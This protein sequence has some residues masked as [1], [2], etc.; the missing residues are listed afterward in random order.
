MPRYYEAGE[1]LDDSRP[2]AGLRSDL[3]QCLSESNCM[4]KEGKSAKECLQVSSSLDQNCR[5]IANTFFQCKR[6]LVDNRNR[7]RGRKG[8]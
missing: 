8:Y 7:F 2:C 6:S 1:V 3:K 4:N 5:A